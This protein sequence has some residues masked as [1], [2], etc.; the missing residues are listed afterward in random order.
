MSWETSDDLA[1]FHRTLAEFCR[2]EMP[3]P[4][5][6]RA[7]AADLSRGK[8]KRAAE[9]MAAEAE[10]GVPL[11]D[12]YEKRQDV[13][14]PLYRSLVAA[15]QATGDL[16]GVLEEIGA[17]ASLRAQAGRRLRKA[18]AWPFVT[19]IF[20]LVVGIGA[21]AWSAPRLWS[22]PG[23]VGATTGYSAPVMLY[24]SV[25][26]VGLFVIGAFLVS[27]LASPVDSFPGF[28]WPGFGRLRL[29]AIRASF[30]S[31]L[32]MLLRRRTPL[33]AACEL[34]AGMFPERHV[35]NG[36]EHMAHAAENGESLSRALG[37]SELFP[38]SMLWLVETADGSEDSARALDD[39]AEIYRDRLDRGLDRMEVLVTPLAELVVGVAVFFFAYSYLVPL[40]E[41]AGKIFGVVELQ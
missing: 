19:A 21:L 16:P 22:V 40:F 28:A 39:V 3:L 1:L 31:T 9:E 36:I 30:A 13:F 4:K 6:F 15:G 23:A 25:G 14:P 41:T 17:H 29:A 10:Q 18:L 2:M 33:P 24:V 32:A 34:T 35:R 26:F 12:A 11:A 20:V 37:R 8:L 27:K 38:E 5:A 7:I